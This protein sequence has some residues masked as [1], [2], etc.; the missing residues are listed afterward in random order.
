MKTDDKTRT[1]L[2]AKATAPATFVLE[3][4]DGT[5]AELDLR[6]QLLGKSLHT[7]RDPAEFT[8]VRVGEW[9][10]ALEWPSGVELG[11]ETLWWRHFPRPDEQ[12]LARFWNGGCGMVCRSPKPRM[13]SVCRAVWLLIIPMARNRFQ[14]RFCS[15]AKDGK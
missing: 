1:I 7:L 8:R 5:R 4:S 11:A 3:G 13:R 9:G 15:H 12:I 10:H 2:A 14:S 6:D